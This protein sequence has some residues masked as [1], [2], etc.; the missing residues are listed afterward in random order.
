M[1]NRL[2]QHSAQLNKLFFIIPLFFSSTAFSHLITGTVTDDTQKPISNVTVQVKGTSRISQTDHAGKYSI[3]AST[4][5]V[6]VFS[7]IVFIKQEVGVNGKQ[8]LNVSLAADTRSMEE[9]MVT[10]LGISKRSRGLGYAATNVK[11]EELTVNRTPNPINALEG[12][13]AGVNI[14][15]LGTGPGGSS[16]IRIRGQSAITVG[17]NSP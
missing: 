11:P 9:V 8:S 1:R 10:A 16:K 12:K 3:D 7:S 6:L 4:T 5:D 14:T 2:R 13:V 15:S 17:D